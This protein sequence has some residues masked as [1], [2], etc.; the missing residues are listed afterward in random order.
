MKEKVKN[1]LRLS[2]EKLVYGGYG[3]S[4]IDGKTVFVRF[5]APKEL[6][7][8]EIIKEKRDYSEAIV[9]KIVLSSP[10][11][12]EA[13]CPYYGICGGCQLQH[14]TY[15]EQL[16]S[17]KNILLE[18]LERIG[19]QKEIPYKG[20]IPSKKEF[21]YRVRV[22]FKVQEGKVGFY[23][24]DKKEVVDIKECLLAHE[25]INSLI[26]HIRESLKVIRDVQEIHV[27]YSP[28]RDEATLKFITITHTEESLIENLLEDVFPP[29]VV[30]IGNYGRVGNTLVKRY[31]VGREH[32]FMDVG[33]W[34]YRVSND[35]FFQVNYTLWED[36][37]KAVLELSDEF[38]KAA[39]LHAG[40]GFFTI[41][42]SEK[43]NFVEGADANPSAVKD[44][45][46]NARLNGRDNVVFTES[47]AYKYL[48]RRAGEIFD[49]ILVDPPRSG[50]FKEE[51]DLL[52][53]NK[54]ERIIYVSCNP[55][56]FARDVKMLSRG[57]YKLTS[58]KLIDNFPQTFHIESIALLELYE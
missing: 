35:S 5:A 56:T 30:G 7:D 15:E 28:S 6:V 37:I 29:W 41:P 26:P 40:V 44:A 32:I 25:K 18:S 21:N 13:P 19:K 17:K 23:R 57:G 45:E 51:I 54:P 16:N 14:I 3:L 9:K 10:S 27:N 42:L 39:D 49:L 53:K 47:T 24:W 36:F 20:E 34:K 58:L 11:R 48:K 43:G 55:T 33:K 2:V 8:A 31:K 12:R 46:Y 1:L 50:L 52:I 22:Q 4:R 38:K